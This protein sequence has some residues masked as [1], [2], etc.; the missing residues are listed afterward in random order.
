MDPRLGLWQTR[1]REVSG[2]DEPHAP[3]LALDPE[4]ALALYT[5]GAAAVSLAAGRRGA[6]APGQ[7]ADWV[8]LSVD[9]LAADPAVVREMTAIE[10]AVAGVT[11]H[12]DQGAPA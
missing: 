11:V 2:G 1:T 7:A 10:T 6:L 8:A 9:P 4:A 5:T 12:T 3:E